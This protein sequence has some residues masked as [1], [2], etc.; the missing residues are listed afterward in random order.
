M[1]GADR[2]RAVRQP[3]PRAGCQG[4]AIAARRVRTGRGSARLAHGG[5]DARQVWFDGA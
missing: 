4:S 3:D 1:G 5:E 2:D